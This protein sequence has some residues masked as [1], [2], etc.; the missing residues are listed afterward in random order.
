M[1]LYDNYQAEV[2]HF[3]R[4]FKPGV[5]VPNQTTVDE[6]PCGDLSNCPRRRL[7]RLATTW[8]Y[9][10]ANASVVAPEVLW[11]Y[12]GGLARIAA[13]SDAGAGS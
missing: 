12:M 8:R 13:A 10:Q 4:R 11:P 3:H 9:Q 5:L 2:T 1:L 7:R 6:F